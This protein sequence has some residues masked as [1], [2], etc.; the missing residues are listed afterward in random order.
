MPIL[1]E[2]TILPNLDNN[3]QCGDWIW[4]MN[5]V[6]F[7]GSA[8]GV[9]LRPFVSHYAHIPISLPTFYGRPALDFWRYGLQYVS[10]ILIFDFIWV[11]WVP[12]GCV[13]SY[14]RWVNCCVFEDLGLTIS[15]ILPAFECLSCCGSFYDIF[16]S[17]LMHLEAKDE[18]E[19]FNDGVCW[20][21]M[22]SVRSG[23]WQSFQKTHMASKNER[24]RWSSAYTNGKFRQMSFKALCWM[25]LSSS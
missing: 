16:R 9:I 1:A 7:L 13:L 23:F 3:L 21:F 12:Q 5:E 15:Y 20:I 19:I 14:W 6:L 8:L 2:V 4:L 17:D 11:G 24:K 25:L 22:M 18:R 10:L